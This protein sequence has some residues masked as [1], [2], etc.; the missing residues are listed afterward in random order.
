MTWGRAGLWSWEPVPA[1]LSLRVF[2]RQVV[3]RTH[4]HSG[5]YRGLAVR[6]GLPPTQTPR[7][8]PPP[9]VMWVSFRGLPTAEPADG[10]GGQDDP[11]SPSQWG[12]RPGLGRGGGG[13]GAGP[14]EVPA[15][16]SWPPHPRGR[17]WETHLLL[18]MVSV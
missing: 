14:E 5:W 10:A 1:S 9:L 7:L 6:E 16:P 2:R 8:Q 13:L 3:D 12:Y 15:G 11:S 4:S 18:L 17:G